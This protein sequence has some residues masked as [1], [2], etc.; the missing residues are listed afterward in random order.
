M[1]T[2]VGFFGAIHACGTHNI[3][4]KGRRKQE[5]INKKGGDK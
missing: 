4:Q 1:P 3:H 5:K 2:I